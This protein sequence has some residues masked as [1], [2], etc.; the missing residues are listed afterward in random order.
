[1]IKDKRKNKK[2]RPQGSTGIDHRMLPVGKVLSEPV[3][4]K[5]MTLPLFGWIGVREKTETPLV[6][7]SVLLLPKNPVESG[8]AGTLQIELPVFEETINNIVAALIRYGWDG[9]VWPRDEGWPTGSTEDEEHLK[10]MLEVS[11]LKNTLVFPTSDQGAAAQEVHVAR[12]AG[13]FLMPP[14]PEADEVDPWKVERL[15][16]LC[17]DPSIFL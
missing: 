8:T 7:L 11:G 6:M 14:L 1:M 3:K 9:R 15:T 13:P 12:A 16:H 2:A 17:N 10:Y 5:F 4:G